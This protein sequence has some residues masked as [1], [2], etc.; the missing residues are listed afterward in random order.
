MMQSQWLNYRR[1]LAD[2]SAAGSALALVRL[3]SLYLY[4]HSLSA[5]SFSQAGEEN[6][7]SIGD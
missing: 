3:S 2:C 5:H 1:V 7:C 4:D 6:S